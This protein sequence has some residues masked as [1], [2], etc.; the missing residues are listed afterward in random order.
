MHDFHKWNLNFQLFQLG[1][2]WQDA[3]QRLI[4][5]RK[6]GQLGSNALQPRKRIAAESPTKA[7]RSRIGKTHQ[8]T[9]RVQ[10]TDN[11]ELG[12]AGDSRAKT[13]NRILHLDTIHNHSVEPRKCATG[14]LSPSPTSFPTAKAH[15]THSFAR[16]KC[17]CLRQA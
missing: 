13:S 8:R 2:K 5:Q 9:A 12:D 10:A 7:Q 1:C 14:Q 16:R 15:R 6:T 4:F 17:S 11:D 3:H